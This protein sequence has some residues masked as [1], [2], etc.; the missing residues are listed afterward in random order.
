MDAATQT[1]YSE[2]EI[3]A[4]IEE[5]RQS[6]DFIHLPFPKDWYKK[7]NIPF[8]APQSVKEFVEEGSW[9]KKHFSPTVER[10]IIKNKSKELLPVLPA[11]EIPVEIITKPVEIQT[12]EDNQQ[13]MTPKSAHST[14]S[15]EKE[16]LD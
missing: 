13:T 14:E 6:P 10:V 15:S 5:L 4:L 7:Y 2:E 12:D 9:Y 3:K 11:P 1:N 16:H 8:L